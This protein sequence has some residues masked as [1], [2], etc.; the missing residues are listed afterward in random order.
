MATNEIQLELFVLISVIRGLN[1][2]HPN[3][4]TQNYLSLRAT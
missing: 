2:S 4:Q 1:I 3:G